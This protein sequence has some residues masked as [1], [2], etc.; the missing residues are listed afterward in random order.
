MM[1]DDRLI[2]MSNKSMNDE[3]AAPFIEYQLYAATYWKDNKETNGVVRCDKNKERT[4]IVSC[5][6]IE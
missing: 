5:K 6:I 2:F 3:N 1:N 4:A